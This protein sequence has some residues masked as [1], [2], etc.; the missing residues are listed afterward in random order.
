MSFGYSRFQFTASHFDS[1]VNDYLAMFL[2]GKSDGEDR[3]DDVRLNMAICLDVSGS[4]SSNLG[5]Q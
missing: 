2:K 4:M 3:S 5:G 1:T